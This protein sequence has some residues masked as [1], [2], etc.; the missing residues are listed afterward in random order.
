MRFNSI[1]IYLFLCLVPLQN[2]VVPGGLKKTEIGAYDG[3]RTDQYNLAVYYLHES[4]GNLAFEWFEKAAE[5][6]HGRAQ[7]NLGVLYQQGVGTQR[8]FKKARYWLER[9]GKQGIP[10]AQLE[11]GILHFWG[12]GL[13][14]NP[15]EA[16]K[17]FRMAARQ[18]QSVALS[19]LGNLY[20]RGRG[21]EKD[22]VKALAYYR[23][24]MLG[25][26]AKAKRW[27]EYLQNQ[28]DEKQQAEARRLAKG[29]FRDL[30]WGMPIAR[31]AENQEY[32]V[33]K[34]S[35]EQIIGL[36][37]SYAGKFY[38]MEWIFLKGVLSRIELMQSFPKLDEEYDALKR[39]LTSIYGNPDQDGYGSKK[40]VTKELVWLVSGLFE[41][42]RIKIQK[43]ES[44]T[45]FGM[46]KK[47]GLRII[48]E[49]ENQ[50]FLDAF[51]PVIESESYSVDVTGVTSSQTTTK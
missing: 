26:D 5:K 31:F 29:D 27:V 51:I 23:M 16:A 38:F 1:L 32:R 9:A 33:E 47:N 41:K 43:T 18:G 7:H 11:M 3:N 45:L 42:T 48:Y 30:R 14:K 28:L 25:G 40:G 15:N 36:E 46:M 19:S 6:G 22:H 13:D 39:R 34:R 35:E 4:R 37:T 17:W 12:R 21:H 10:E 24:G 8:D 20:F 50:D 2:A 44:P 49:P